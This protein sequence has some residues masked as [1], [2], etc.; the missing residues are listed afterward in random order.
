M[1]KGAAE[2]E[3]AR[4]HVEL[5]REGLIRF[6]G[7]KSE[8]E[9]ENRRLDDQLSHCRAMESELTRQGEHTQELEKTLLM[10]KE[11]AESSIEARS[12]IEEKLAGS[13]LN[14][15]LRKICWQPRRQKG[16]A[17]TSRREKPPN[18]HIS[19]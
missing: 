11:E 1:S 4:K 14:L 8:L 12:E 9:S 17:I 13:W 5:T 7:I 15:R 3:E 19:R 18:R 6:Q 2:S 16:K 10:E